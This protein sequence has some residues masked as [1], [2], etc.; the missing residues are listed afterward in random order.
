M[1]K[2]EVS[3]WSVFELNAM[4]RTLHDRKVDVFVKNDLN[5]GKVF[6]CKY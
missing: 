2:I 6:L 3:S 4:L 1:E 5:N